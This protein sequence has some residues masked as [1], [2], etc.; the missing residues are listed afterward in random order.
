M[1]TYKI[2]VLNLDTDLCVQ[3]RK[4][5]VVEGRGD[6]RETEERRKTREKKDLS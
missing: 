2:V 5:K 6:R 4:K 1:Y 3:A